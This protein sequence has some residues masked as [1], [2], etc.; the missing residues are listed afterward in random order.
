M[1][2]ATITAAA[3]GGESLR[4]SAAGGDAAVIWLTSTAIDG[5]ADRHRKALR[6]LNRGARLTAA[7]ID[8]VVQQ[9]WPG[10]GPR[11]AGL[12]LIVGSGFGNQGETTRYFQAILAGGAEAVTPMASYDVSVNSFVSFASI[13]F[14]IRNVVHT[15]SS[16]ATSGADALV[17]AL[18]MLATG[19]A[20]AV[21]VA[22]VEPDSAEAYGYANGTRQAGEVEACAVLL[23]ETA[24]ARVPPY[25]RLLGAETAFASRAAGRREAVLAGLVERLLARGRVPDTLHAVCA[26]PPWGDAAALTRR[27]GTFGATWVGDDDRASPWQIGASAV[28]DCVRM[29]RHLRRSPTPGL[30]LVV[31]ADPDGWLGAVLLAANAPVHAVET[32]PDTAV[33]VR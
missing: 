2:E 28:V 12:S 19:E 32:A 26:G 30:G 9:R 33:E 7:V 17:S 6:Y 18:A 13:F 21:L 11:P 27:I 4:V 20:D 10:G 15:V 22:G 24:A 3:V 29:L 8:A 25:G 14:G 1:T 16:G 23:L 5:F 31:S